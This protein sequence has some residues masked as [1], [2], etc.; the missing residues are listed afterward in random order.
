[1]KL[2]NC[3]CGLPV[4]SHS[5][6]KYCQHKRTDEKYI[7]K[8]TVTK[9]NRMKQPTGEAV[10][11]ATIISTRKPISFLS[12]LNI[13]DIDGTID[14]NNCHHALVKGKFPNFRP[15]KITP[16]QWMGLSTLTRL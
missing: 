7:K 10:L 14:H 4:F 13:Y 5:F 2:C 11:F 9:C 6:S 12:G 16:T 3:G 8:Q 15:Q 1:M